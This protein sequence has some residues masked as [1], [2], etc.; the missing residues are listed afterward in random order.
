[1]LRRIRELSLCVK[2][3]FHARYCGLYLGSEFLNETGVKA[4]VFNKIRLKWLQDTRHPHRCNHQ[5]SGPENMNNFFGCSMVTRL[6]FLVGIWVHITI[7]RD[8]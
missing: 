2:L 6:P 7:N 3:N 5:G 1:M 8:F 4:D